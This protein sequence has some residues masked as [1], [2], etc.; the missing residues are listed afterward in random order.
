MISFSVL[1]ILAAVVGVV[2]I[3]G[4]FLAIVVAIGK[5]QKPVYKSDTLKKRPLFIAIE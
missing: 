2:L 4:L 3:G 1:F 5:K